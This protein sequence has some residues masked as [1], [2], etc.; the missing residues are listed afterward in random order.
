MVGLRLNRLAVGLMDVFPANRLSVWWGWV[1][2]VSYIIVDYVSARALFK[3]DTSTKL[4]ATKN[5][6]Q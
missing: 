5:V 1:G 3:S 2:G 4:I 6:S